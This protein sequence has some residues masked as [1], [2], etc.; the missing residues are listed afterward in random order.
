[1]LS[2]A[3]AANVRRGSGLVSVSH[4]NIGIQTEHILKPIYRPQSTFFSAGYVASLS[5]FR[6]FATVSSEGSDS[7]FAPKKAPPAPQTNRDV[8]AE[9]KKV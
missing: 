6:K 8:A 2:K 1:M 5:N 4:L 7:D 9:I 3:V